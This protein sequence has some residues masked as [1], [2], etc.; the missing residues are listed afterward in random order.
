[1]AR[2]TDP[3]VNGAGA[4]GLMTARELTRAG[5][6]VLV[7]EASARVGGRVHT[8]YDTGAGV[9]IE[10]GAEF[11]HGDAPVTTQLLDEARL[12]PL[13]V[14]GEHYRSDDGELVDQGPAFDRMS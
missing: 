12:P 2:S 13:R 6:H 4:A 1:M 9:P 5:K 10:L 11:V 8:E 14:L 3:T 7:L